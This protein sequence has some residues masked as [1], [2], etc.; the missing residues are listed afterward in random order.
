M[1][2]NIKMIKLAHYLVRKEGKFKVLIWIV[3]RAIMVS[4]WLA[5]MRFQLSQAS[6]KD[7]PCINIVYILYIQYS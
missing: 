6:V 5:L 2:G 3:M 1:F 7:E 4:G